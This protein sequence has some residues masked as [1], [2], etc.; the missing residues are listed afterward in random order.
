MRLLPGIA[1]TL[2]FSC[3]AS[4]YA[5]D[6][7]AIPA[8]FGA[9]ETLS[10]HPAYSFYDLPADDSDLKSDPEAQSLV[11]ARRLFDLKFMHPLA[12]NQFLYH[13]FNSK[14][15]D[16]VEGASAPN[17]LVGGPSFRWGAERFAI[18]VRHQ[19]IGLD[20][21]NAASPVRFDALALQWMHELDAENA[22]ALSAQVGDYNYRSADDRLSGPHDAAST[23]ASFGWVSKFQGIVMQPRLSGSVFLGDETT[24][25]DNIRYYGRRFYG[26]KMDGSFSLFQDHTPYAS[27]QIQRS[28]YDSYDA[29]YLGARRDDYSRL[30]A[31]WNWQVNP[32][33]GLRAEANRSFNNSNLDLYEYARHQFFFTTRF[34]FR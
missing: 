8:S 4:S 34:D 33:W 21:A 28:D 2:S 26:L 25:N 20:R 30:A 19:Q 3:V 6:L 22:F 12:A 32:N 17:A 13:D 7:K 15:E 16:N 10:W 29:L 27:I 9:S 24:R 11:E 1:F 5:S 18:P 23:L 14:S 31:G